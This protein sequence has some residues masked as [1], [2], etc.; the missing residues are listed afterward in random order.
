MPVSLETYQIGQYWTFIEQTKLELKNGAQIQTL[1]DLKHQNCR[2]TYK[3]Y[4]IK[5]RIPIFIRTVLKPFVGNDEN[6]ELHEECE[7]EFP[8]CKTVL[9]NPAYLKENFIVEIESRLD[10]IFFLKKITKCKTI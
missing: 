2:K 5:H 8:Y 4:Q 10:M 1:S 7:E 3:V 6:Y 9:K